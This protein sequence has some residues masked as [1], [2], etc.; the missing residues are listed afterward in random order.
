[1]T[2]TIPKGCCRHW[3]RFPGEVF[4]PI[5]N[6]AFT[7]LLDKNHVCSGSEEAVAIFTG[8]P[9]S[10]GIIDF[11]VDYKTLRSV[12]SDPYKVEAM[13]AESRSEI[14]RLAHATKKAEQVWFDFG[15]E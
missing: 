2:E 7:R 11:W 5:S 3:L 6:H 8:K 13:I 9:D 4:F 10:G 12:A 1:L 14:T 15:G